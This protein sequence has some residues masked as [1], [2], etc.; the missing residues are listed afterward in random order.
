M[1]NLLLGLIAIM[2][3]TFSCTTEPQTIE[4]DDG[5]NYVLRDSQIY[6]KVDPIQVAVAELMSNNNGRVPT[7][8][9]VTEE[10]VGIFIN[11]SITLGLTPGGDW[12]DTGWSYAFSVQ[13][14]AD[15]TRG[16]SEEYNC[17]GDGWHVFY[18]SDT[19]SHYYSSG[20]TTTAI[21][22]LA[23]KNL[24]QNIQRGP[25]GSPSEQALVDY[26]DETR[27]KDWDTDVQLRF[28]GCTFDGGRVYMDGWGLWWA[29][30]DNGNT[31]FF[32]GGPLQAQGYCWMVLQ[33]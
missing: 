32:W 8:D 7:P 11:I 2:A 33:D 28:S 13:Y 19:G 26:L 17:S 10:G 21:S 6:K 25:V 20:G 9:C 23:A 5:A 31:Y 3:V 14:C 12:F 4:L 29:E 27:D 30:F 1:K 18:S 15:R 22:T 16:S 24:C